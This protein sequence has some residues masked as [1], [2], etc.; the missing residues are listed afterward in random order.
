MK[1]RFGAGPQESDWTPASDG[2]A[3]RE[4]NRRVLKRPVL[5][6]VVLLTRFHASIR[7]RAIDLTVAR[8]YQRETSG[9]KQRRSVLGQSPNGIGPFVFVGDPNRTQ[10]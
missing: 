1:K 2:C 6:E 8:G 5:F 10:P 3:R 4:D 7:L 9:Q